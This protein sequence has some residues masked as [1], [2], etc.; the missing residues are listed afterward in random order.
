MAEHAEL[1]RQQLGFAALGLQ[2]SQR[3]VDSGRQVTGANVVHAGKTGRGAQ[4]GADPVLKQPH[5]PALRVQ[6][7]GE[8]TFAQLFGHEGQG[9]LGKAVEQDDGLEAPQALRGDAG[10]HP[11]L[12][13]THQADT[14]SLGLGVGDI[15]T[16]TQGHG[17]AHRRL[18]EHLATTGQADGRVLVRSQFEVAVVG[19]RG[20]VGGWEVF[21]VVGQ[22]EVEHAA[23]N[24]VAQDS[25]W[26][27][28]EGSQ[29]VHRVGPGFHLRRNAAHHL[30]YV[31]G[32]AARGQHTPALGLHELHIELGQLVPH[33]A[34]LRGGPAAVPKFFAQPSP[35]LAPAQGW[36][37]HLAA[38]QVPVAFAIAEREAVV[39]GARRTGM[40][41]QLEAIPDQI[42]QLLLL[43][44]LFLG[45]LTV[46]VP[47]CDSVSE[48]CP[49]RAACAA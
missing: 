34:A 48:T 30:G 3:M 6:H 15:G 23:A 40:P 39:K 22:P 8:R 25:E 17:E 14:D 36:L 2:H 26:V 46:G 4:E 32:Q 37:D 24:H 44:T 41:E 20:R 31:H 47:T 10:C 21:F 12:G 35:E 9:V 33:T 43:F 16:C 28:D 13:V 45:A 5:I 42:D 19:Q 49:H 27:G 7:G 29:G 38:L 1:A 11:R 18:R